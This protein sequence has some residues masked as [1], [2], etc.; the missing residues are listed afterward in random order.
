MYTGPE[1]EKAKQELQDRLNQEA[2]KAMD[3]MRVN[4]NASPEQLMVMG[5]SNN[6]QAVARLYRYYR[7]R[8]DYLTHLFLQ[9]WPD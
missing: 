6:D 2:R 7:K 1:Y 3:A 9:K 5:F 4:Y 8:M